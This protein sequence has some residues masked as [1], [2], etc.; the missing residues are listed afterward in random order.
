VLAGAALTVL[1]AGGRDLNASVLR[2]REGTRGSTWWLVGPTSLALRLSGP[3]ALGWLAGIA[4]FA[5]MLGSFAQS[6][7]SILATSPA[8]TATLGRLGVRTATLGFLGFS[9][10]FADLIIAVMAASQIGA[11]RDEEAAGRL[12]NLLVRPVSRVTWL[13]SRLG[14][15][16]AFVLLAGLAAG[17]FTWVGV[18][19]HH[20]YVAL[21]SLLEAGINATIPGVFVLGA[22]ALVLGLGP[23]LSSV[24]AYG[25]VAWSFLVD[26]LGSLIRGADW[27]RDSSLFTHIAL[28]PSV[29]PDWGTDA[30]IVVLGVAAAAI[31]AVAFQRRDV[32]YT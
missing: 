11:I 29:K 8:I 2:E 14:V 13:A 18:T 31:G 17:F 10:F 6:A 15:S 22:G 12:D 32:E 30:V 21:P 26:L 4:G 7:V 28:A 3:A 5:A 19:T 27:L 23:R 1:L 9:L 20:T 25:I 24:V 16:L